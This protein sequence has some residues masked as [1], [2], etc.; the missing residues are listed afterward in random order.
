MSSVHIRLPEAHLEAPTAE[1]VILAGTLL[2]VWRYGFLGFSLLSIPMGY[3]F[4]AFGTSLII[5]QRYAHLLLPAGEL[6]RIYHGLLT[7]MNPCVIVC[8]YI[9]KVRNASFCATRSPWAP[10]VL[11][12]QSLKH[13]IATFEKSKHNLA[14]VRSWRCKLQSFDQRFGPVWEESMRPWATIHC[15]NLCR[16][17]YS[18]FSFFPVRRYGFRR[19]GKSLN[20]ACKL[21]MQAAPFCTSH[22]LLLCRVF[23]KQLKLLHVGPH[24]SKER[25]RYATTRNMLSASDTPSFEII[26]LWCNRSSLRN[27]LLLALRTPWSRRPYFPTGF[28]DL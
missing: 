16:K 7:G 10:T 20:C 23:S 15:F 5:V 3:F 24:M 1:S 26:L 27:Y 14:M 13:T 2:C 21:R 18:C 22:H 9:F 12:L 8:Y 25:L 4:L 17:F 19:R 28:T 11:L 6:I